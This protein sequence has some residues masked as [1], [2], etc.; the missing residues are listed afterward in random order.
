METNTAHRWK[1]IKNIGGRQHRG[2]GE[3]KKKG[4]RDNNEAKLG[5][6][7]ERMRRQSECNEEEERSKSNESHLNFS[8]P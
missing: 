3:K 7:Q 8:L 2:G 1:K 4:N 6:T 5:K